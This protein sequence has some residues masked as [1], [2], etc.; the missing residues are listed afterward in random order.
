MP[1]GYSE[2]NKNEMIVDLE[3]RL[4]LLRVSTEAIHFLDSVLS[5]TSSGHEAV[6]AMLYERAST[7][8][9]AWSKKEVKELMGK[10]V[11]FISKTQ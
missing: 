6:V 4:K 8:P 9:A 7:S 1:E 11:N 2:K 5:L 10:N 3:D